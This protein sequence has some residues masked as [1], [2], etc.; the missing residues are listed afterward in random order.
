MGRATSKGNEAKSKMKHPSDIPTPR[1]IFVYIVLQ[2]PL[3]PK[4]YINIKSS[5]R[6]GLQP[7]TMDTNIS[8]PHKFSSKYSANMLT[9]GGSTA[10]LCDHLV[11]GDVPYP[12]EFILS[13]CY[14]SGNLIDS[15]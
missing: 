4:E 13:F 5:Y 9:S 3:E 10:T 11:F 14:D 6:L 12:S 7:V 2:I 15:L 8:V 1:Y